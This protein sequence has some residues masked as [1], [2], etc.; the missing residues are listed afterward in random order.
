VSALFKS[1]S[2]KADSLSPTQRSVYG[3]D[4]PTRDAVDRMANRWVILITVALESG[5][6][7]FNDLK[8]Q[9]GVSSQVL[10]RV[11]RDLVRDGLVDR[12]VY[13]EVPVRV[14]YSLTELGGTMCDPVRAVRAWAEAVSSEIAAARA[15]YDRAHPDEDD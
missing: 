4:T 1:R 3:H 13:A 15:D 6:T 12:T 9:L 8:A 10:T 7:R 14:E 5:P 11:L 2:S